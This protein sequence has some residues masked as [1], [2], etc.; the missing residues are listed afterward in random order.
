MY[1]AVFTYC[2]YSDCPFHP[3]DVAPPVCV[4][5]QPA[6]TAKCNKEVSVQFSSGKSCSIEQSMENAVQDE[7]RPLLSAPS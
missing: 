5:N 3:S 1:I 6:M 7:K 2:C 4:K